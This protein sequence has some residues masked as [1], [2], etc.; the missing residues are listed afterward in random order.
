M[1][2][3]IK[4]KI[5]NFCKKWKEPTI[6][7]TTFNNNVTY[8]N[9]FVVMGVILFLVY[10]CM[11]IL[12][13]NSKVNLFAILLFL[14]YI[15][16]MYLITI[17]RYKFSPKFAFK[18]NEEINDIKKF[19]S[20]KIGELNFIWKRGVGVIVLYFILVFITMFIIP[21]LQD[22]STWV[23][24]FATFFIIIKLLIIDK[25]GNFY[26][27][28]KNDYNYLHYSLFFFPLLDFFLLT[29][30]YYSKTNL[31]ASFVDMVF[32][33]KEFVLPIIFFILGIIIYISY[34]RAPFE[35]YLKRLNKNYFS[36]LKGYGIFMAAY[37]LFT[38][39]LILLGVP[40]NK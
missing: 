5:K 4:I 9:L 33:N 23:Y 10:F 17:F 21:Y 11:A 37:M 31:T 34:N 36:L 2:G 35:E 32:N 26:S 25:I 29:L 8:T 12:F 13:K 6:L 7:L 39:Q 38:L 40:K 20:N 15:I 22:I 3:N 16:I 24:L 27:I 19:H 1:A 30:Y 18:F 14:I 28:I